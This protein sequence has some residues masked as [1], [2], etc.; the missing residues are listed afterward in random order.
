[1]QGDELCVDEV[2]ARRE[3]SEHELED[4]EAVRV[5]DRNRAED[6]KDEQQ[7]RKER[8]KG[9]VRDGRGMRQVAPVEQP[10]ERSPRGEA[11]QPEIRTKTKKGPTQRHRAI[12][13]WG[14]RRAPIL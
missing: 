12:I 3:V 9:V 11:R 14:P 10:H 8:E 5:I 13:A 6:R 2:D 1:M 4:L 7:K